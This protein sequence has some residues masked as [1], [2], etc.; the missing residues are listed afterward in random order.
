MGNKIQQGQIQGLKEDLTTLG[1]RINATGANLKDYIN[2]EIDEVSSN[3]V[4]TGQSLLSSISSATGA[5]TN[6]FLGKSG[7]AGDATITN[8]SWNGQLNG[9][10]ED[11]QGIFD[12]IDDIL[13]LGG[14]NLGN[15]TATQALQMSNYNITGA[16]G[17]SAKYYLG[18]GDSISLYTGDWTGNLLNAT[19]TLA[20][21]AKAVD[22]LVAGAGGDN[23]GN[24]T[25]TQTLNLNNN[26]ITGA[27]IVTG[28]RIVA[29]EYNESDGGFYGDGRSLTVRESDVFP[30]WLGE[31]PSVTKT[32]LELFTK[33]DA[34]TLNKLIDYNGATGDLYVSV[35][36]SGKNIFGSGDSLFLNTG[37]WT[38][39]LSGSQNNLSS[40]LSRL[41]TLTASN[42]SIDTGNLNNI[43]L[44]SGSTVKQI[45][46]YIDE[47]LYLKTAKS[48]LNLNGYSITGAGLVNTS[49]GSFIQLS[50]QNIIGEGSGIYIEEGKVRTGILSG[51]DSNYNYLKNI[52]DRID[53]SGAIKGA[54][55]DN[56]GNHRATQDI[57]LQ[58]FSITGVNEIGSE[59]D[60]A[61]NISAINISASTILASN[62]RIYESI[63]GD[64]FMMSLNT[65]TGESGIFKNISGQSLIFST[66]DINDAT[67]ETIT[68]ESIN[69]DHIT[70]DTI[71]ATSGI[72]SNFSG[73]VM[74]ANELT[75][76]DFLSANDVFA[77][78]SVSAPVGAFQSLLTVDVISFGPGGE[79]AINGGTGDQ[80]RLNSSGWVGNLAG[81]D[82]SLSGLANKVDS[83][84]M[85]AEQSLSLNSPR[86]SII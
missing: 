12:F 67:F 33:I 69:T 21:L 25:A 79:I 52:V 6:V 57:D 4:S 60:P 65:V 82:G 72:F 13:G 8:S 47:N 56:L 73:D 10:P 36:L 9:A 44:S 58:G 24:H 38:G 59:E 26:N 49:T 16:S 29:S 64:G 83:L 51:I 5:L 32:F 74:I 31:S 55:R 40:A 81:V 86:H 42:L 1:S 77:Q 54:D 75:A 30:N 61:I 45:F 84:S 18:S 27:N 11:L 62:L 35:N 41:N 43:L 50:A 71:S 7:Y 2:D 46:E 53:A 70:T 20:G 17:I 23:L 37:D 68:A 28:K 76:T 34:L 80:I 14:D 39:I 22:I 66:C 48:N 15:H 78:N 19:G 63:T 85:G 3:L